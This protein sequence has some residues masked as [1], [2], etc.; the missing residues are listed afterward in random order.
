MINPG[1]FLKKVRELGV[2]S[3]F[4]V[5]DSLLKD[6]CL[7]ID[8]AK[9]V[10]HV[11][12]ANEGAAIAAATGSYLATGQAS[13]V[14]LQNSGLGNT[15]N[16]LLSLAD[17]SVYAIP[18]VLL[19]G[20]R[21]EP[22]VSDEPQH[23]KQGRTTTAL[24][25]AM[26]IPW[27]VLP[28]EDSESAVVVEAALKQ[29]EQEKSPVALLVSKGTFSSYSKKGVVSSVIF[30]SRE[31]ALAATVG[32][33]PAHSFVVASTGVL[34][35]ELY[36][37]RAVDQKKRLDLLNVGAMGHAISIA[38]GFALAEPERP[39]W[40]LDGDGSVI[41]H[42]GSLAVTGSE[43]PANLH[44]VVFNN[45]VHDSVGGQATAASAFSLHE[46]A[47]AVGYT[48]CTRATTIAGLESQIGE[49]LAAT[50]PSFLEMM[51][52]PGFRADLGR[53]REEPGAATRELMRNLSA[54]RLLE[55]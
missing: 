41:M 34:G 38:L 31:E 29:A 18:M 19:I 23:I 35:R 8:Q 47:Q 20:W 16:P 24:L 4:G 48:Q 15:V 44:H 11:I 2:S 42:M 27:Q 39:V 33:I 12:T 54:A 36:E 1:F 32:A 49:S 5:P 3:F 45:E 17:Q 13:L 52:R 26:E 53:P 21:G 7:A 30:P 43:A 10:T 22:G 55:K 9:D 50:G 6:F 37:L 51:V 25:E 14:Y 40:C 46:V 28:T